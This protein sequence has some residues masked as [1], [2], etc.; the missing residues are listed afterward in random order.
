ML[1]QST[2]PLLFCLITLASGC[3]ES[4]TN[5]AAPD[6]SSLASTTTVESAV[7]RE[8][9]SAEKSQN[10][11]RASQAETRKNDWP[12]W[13]GPNR[14]GISDETGLIHEFPETGP[15]ILWRKS[16]GTGFSG[17]TVA[18][19]RVFTMFG[20]E[21][22]E[23]IVCFDADTGDEVWKVDS[24]ADFAQGRSFGPRSTPCG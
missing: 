24:D 21:G 15:K 20:E 4:S 14:N 12:H 18:G 3:S 10:R 8:K 11:P 13:R 6:S 9:R 17:L 19:G 1:Y 7:P 5:A 16:L 22:R 2:L 23:K